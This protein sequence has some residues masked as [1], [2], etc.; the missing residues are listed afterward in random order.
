[1]FILIET[2]DCELLTVRTFQHLTDA[3]DLFE[4]LAGPAEH[5][6]D[7]DDLANE[8][9]GTVAFAGDDVH[10]VQVIKSE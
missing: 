6:T 2:G 9:P 4:T 1:M 8:V 10:A 7:A 3:M 5:L